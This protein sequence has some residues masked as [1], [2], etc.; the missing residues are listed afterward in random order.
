[1]AT[2]EK[3]VRYARM[4]GVTMAE[5]HARA[6]ETEAN[7]QDGNLIIPPGETAPSVRPTVDLAAVAASLQAMALAHRSGLPVTKAAARDTVAL[8][9]SEVRGVLGLPAPKGRKT[10]GQT[11]R[12][13]GQTISQGLVP[14]EDRLVANGHAAD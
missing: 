14:G 13:N 10:N 7:R 4:A 2:R 12:P 1:M 11:A 5:W 8:I 9:R 6:V 3:A